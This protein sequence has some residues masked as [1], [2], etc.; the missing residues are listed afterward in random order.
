MSKAEK[1]R[2]KLIDDLFNTLTDGNVPEELGIN[3]ILRGTSIFDLSL[4][5]NE[6]NLQDYTQGSQDKLIDYLSR[7]IEGIV[8][9]YHCTQDE[10]KRPYLLVQRE[11]P[12][13]ESKLYLDGQECDLNEDCSCDNE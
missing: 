6:G 10:E 5:I 11:D 13:E 12:K 4:S 3:S 9:S 2:Q 8:V 7:N 1:P